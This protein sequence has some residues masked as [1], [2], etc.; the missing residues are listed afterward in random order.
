MSKRTKLRKINLTSVDMVRRGANQEAYI[1]LYKSAGDPAEPNAPANAPAAPNSD[2]IERG[3][4]KSIV[5]AVKGFMG[6]KE[7]IYGESGM[8][9]DPDILE[10]AAE[11]FQTKRDQQEIRDDR[12]KYQ[13]ALNMSIDSILFDDSLTN[14]QKSGMLA[15]SIQQFADAYKELCVKLLNT[16]ANTDTATLAVPALAVGKSQDVVPEKDEEGEEEMRI[17]KSRFTEEELAQ[18]LALVNKGKVDDEPAEGA[19][20]TEPEA[21]KD[22][23]MHPEVKK[24]L[25]DMAALTKS[26]EMK[27]LTDVAKKYE[28]LGKNADELAGTLYEMKKSSQ[29][30]YD[31][32]LA[33][34]DQ[35]LDLVNKSGLFEEIGKSNHTPA[36]GSTVAKI[37]AIA[38]EL[39]KSDVSLDRVGAIAK[40][41]EQHPELVAQYDNEYMGGK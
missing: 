25:E 10:K 24:A 31:A 2:E 40:A 38:T 17:D 33:V 22:N 20:S 32:Y 36:G 14:E 26:I 28:P 9:D 34:L 23:E 16:T 13:D 8:S 35:N 6:K 4:V 30:S 19:N 21:E 27:E 18:Y 41:W 1:N 11:S 15:E 3:L 5:D 12:W 39:Q 37:E 29:A 7:V